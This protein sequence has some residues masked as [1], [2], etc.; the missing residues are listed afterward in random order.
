MKFY[1]NWFQDQRGPF[2]VVFEGRQP[3]I[4][5]SWPKAKYQVN[6]F[7]G[8]CHKKFPTLYEAVDSFTEYCTFKTQLANGEAQQALVAQ[9]NTITDE[10][11]DKIADEFTSLWLS[12]SPSDLPMPRSLHMPKK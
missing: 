3:G 12:P 8:S 5:D 9:T 10:E 11:V 7:S 6:G 2:W 4:Y 1:F